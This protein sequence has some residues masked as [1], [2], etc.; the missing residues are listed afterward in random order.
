MPVGF[1]E[2]IAN[3]G[4]Y[5]RLDAAGTGAN[6]KQSD[7]KHRALS[8]GDSPRRGHAREG[9]IA[10]AVNDRERKD[11][12]IFTEYPVGDNRPENWQEVDAEH[13][14]MRG[15]CT[16]HSN[17]SA[18]D[19]GLIQDVMRHED[20]QDRLHAVIGEALSRFVADNVRHARRH[21][22]E[23]R[24]RSQIL[25]SSHVVFCL[26]SFLWSFDAC[27]LRVLLS[28]SRPDF[29][30]I[31]LFPLNVWQLADGMFFARRGKQENA[32]GNRDDTLPNERSHNT[33][34]QLSV[35]GT[36]CKNESVLVCTGI[37][38]C[39]AGGLP[40]CRTLAT[41]CSGETPELP[42][43][44]MPVLLVIERRRWGITITRGGPH[45]KSQ[46]LE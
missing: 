24:W 7:R 38:A 44:K 37:F 9:E 35:S 36:A 4:R 25:V 3:V 40:A 30:R 6:E 34:A 23:V 18:P 22:G 29:C 8:D 21:A 19:T 20:G 14:I 12:P 43:G 11:G 31:G 27:C 5:T 13:E 10:Q 15:T 28:P 33:L 26:T 42:T 17:S 2:L 46:R 39:R 45:R 1:A 32:Q 16:P 41:K